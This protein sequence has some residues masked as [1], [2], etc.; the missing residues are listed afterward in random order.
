M[1]AVER[2]GLLAGIA[3][4]VGRGMRILLL[5]LV[6][7]G[8]QVDDEA[9]GEEAGLAACSDGESVAFR[10]EAQVRGAPFV[11]FGAQFNQN[12]YAKAGG[13]R[14]ASALPGK[15]ASLAPEHVRIFFDS[16]ALGDADLMQSFVRTVELAQQ[17]GATVNV[18]WWHGP[19][20]DLAGAMRQF[21]AVLD[22]LVNRRGLAAVRYV[23]I[24]NEVNSTRVTMA[25]YERLYRVLDAELR[26]RGLRG[27]IELVGGDLLAENQ[28]AWFSYL[29]RR[30]GDVLDGY[31]VHIYWDYRE[32]DKLVR[33]LT[34]VREL[35]DALPARKPLY[36]TEFGV[37][38]LRGDGEAQPGHVAGGTPVERSP[39]GAL[40]QAWFDILAARLGYVATV[41]WDAYFAMYDANPQYFSLI[42]ESG[43]EKPSYFLLRLLTHTVDPGWRVS[44][45]HGG[46][47]G[48]V[49]AAFRGDGETTFLAAN[50]SDCRR[51]L[52]VSGLPASRAL[53]F[54]VWNGDGKGHLAAHPRPKTSGAGQVTIT[55]PPRAVV[56]L[57][58][59]LPGLGL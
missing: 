40:Q 26:A 1:G 36:V 5:L 41:R 30:M 50:V 56:A 34:E 22:D 44:T 49:A 10:V 24:Q 53:Y 7:C 25:E 16:R 15:L 35:A 46:A 13:V 52:R 27:H 23:T 39:L 33:R 58:T 51:E 18:T 3:F 14:D 38:G 4:A 47:P 17:A 54:I 45:V 6:G 43:L 42:G 31:S 29:G 55:V 2:R 48:A 59:R 11:G 19:Y 8:G 12:L 57:A 32:P 20:P 9:A 37:R 28:A 21:A